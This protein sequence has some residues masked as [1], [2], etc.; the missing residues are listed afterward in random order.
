MLRPLDCKREALPDMED[1]GQPPRKD[2]AKKSRRRP[3]HRVL[4]LAL[5]A[6]VGLLLLLQCVS[7]LRLP[8]DAGGP[9]AGTYG[10]SLAALLPQP[11]QHRPFSHAGGLV[12]TLWRAADAA[13][14]WPPSRKSAPGLGAALALALFGL[15]RTFFASQSTSE[16][17][18]KVRARKRGRLLAQM[19]Q[20]SLMERERVRGGV[21]LESSTGVEHV[22]Q[23]AGSDAQPPE[24]EA[25]LDLLWDSEEER[26][27]L[28]HG[29]ADSAAGAALY[30]EMR[31]LLRQRLKAELI[32]S[33]AKAEAADRGTWAREAE[34]AALE[35]HAGG[36]K[37]RPLYQRLKKDVLPNFKAKW[38]R[39]PAWLR[40]EAPKD[41]TGREPLVDA[42]LKA[43]GRAAKAYLK[44]RRSA[45]KILQIFRPVAPVFGLG[46]SLFLFE[47]AVGPALWAQMF[48]MLDG[49][50]EKTTAPA[51][52]RR[53]LLATFCKWAVFVLAHARGGAD[54]SAGVFHT[55]ASC[56]SS[57]SRTGLGPH[58][59]RQGAHGVRVPGEAR[60]HGGDAAAGHGVLRPHALG[61]A[62]G[63][64][65][66]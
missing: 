22:T 21:E 53:E 24:A 55:R 10:F 8:A 62:A 1:G 23:A 42:E 35:A 26:H 20:T 51:A 58:V 40:D 59:H 2:E 56:R 44:K 52:F 16:A 63:A 9:A 19:A 37:L 32:E 6:P 27:T 57:R 54:S 28:E 48:A 38:R 39:P 50:A 7:F 66:V 47:S 31:V 25:L 60:G 45:T 15:Y 3:L 5:L 36:A 33:L 12:L 65:G 43:L 61:R 17:S 29:V 18:L 34:A 4:L 46:L 13:Y 41:A 64:A 14:L 49:L 11:L 30:E